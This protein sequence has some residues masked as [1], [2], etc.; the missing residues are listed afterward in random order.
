MISLAKVLIG[1]RHKRKFYRMEAN[2]AQGDRDAQLRVKHEFVGFSDAVEMVMQACKQW[3]IEHPKWD[4][5]L[6]DQSMLVRAIR[7]GPALLASGNRT[8]A[9]EHLK[10]SIRKWEE[11]Q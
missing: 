1:L 8:K 7:R 10:K 6:N 11:A 9:I 5:P 3:R 4:V 2:R